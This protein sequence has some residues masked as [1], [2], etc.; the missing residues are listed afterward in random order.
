MRRNTEK[1]STRAER[2]FFEEEVPYGLA[3]CRICLPI[4]LLSM[5]LP[6]WSTAR[7][8]FSI[9]GAT[10]PL[11]IGYGYLNLLPEFP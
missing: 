11:A 3:L 9:E 1:L 7:E 2:F 4:A 8:L 6:R 5:A 10:A